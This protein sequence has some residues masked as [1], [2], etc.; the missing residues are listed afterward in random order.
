MKSQLAAW[1]SWPGA[2]SWRPAVRRELDGLQCDGAGPPARPPRAR[3]GCR[4]APR[5]P[6]GE[7]LG[8]V[9]LRRDL[10]ARLLTS[11]RGER[12]GANAVHSEATRR[13]ALWPSGARA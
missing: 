12:T 10:P 11:L 13:S 6:G 9:R 4:G 7:L 2:V 1:L 3:G 5:D 8:A